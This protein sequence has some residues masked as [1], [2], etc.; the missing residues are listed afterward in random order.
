[1]VA[2]VEERDAAACGGGGDLFAGGELGEERFGVVEEAGGVGEVRHVAQDSGTR[3]GGELGGDGLGAEDVGDVEVMAVG[4]ATLGHGELMLLGELLLGHLEHMALRPFVERAVLEKEGL[5]ALDAGNFLALR[6]VAEL[7]RRH[8]QVRGGALQIH[9]L[10]A[11][12]DI[13]PQLPLGGVRKFVIQCARL[14]FF[15]ESERRKSWTLR[16][17]R[18]YGST[19]ARS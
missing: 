9:Q 12:G 3:L 4:V 14:L 19:S 11:H 5:P 8:V 18:G 16:L 15:C 7:V 1:M 13:L 10:V 2:R 17:Q 6:E